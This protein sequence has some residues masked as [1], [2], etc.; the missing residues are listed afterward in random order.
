VR[1]LQ[2]QPLYV[3]PQIAFIPFEYPPLYFWVSALVAKIVGIG[4]FPLRL[5]SFSVVSRMFRVHLSDRQN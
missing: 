4:F 5:V 2:H 3:P 1:V